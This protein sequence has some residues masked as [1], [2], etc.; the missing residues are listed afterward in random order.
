MDDFATGTAAGATST[1]WTSPAQTGAAAGG[2][3]SVIWLLMARLLR[4]GGPL[5]GTALGQRSR[6]SLS[7][8]RADLG[9]HL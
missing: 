5:G 8:R 7:R 6:Q 9:N 1:G 3:S 4:S 2:C